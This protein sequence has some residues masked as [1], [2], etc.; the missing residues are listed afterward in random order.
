M[1]R[2]LTNTMTVLSSLLLCTA[3]IYDIEDD[4]TNSPATSTT[5]STYLQIDFNTQVS[6]ATKADAD[7]QT[8]EKTED[9]QT[10]ENEIASAAVFLYTSETGVNDENAGTIHVIPILFDEG[11]ITNTTIGDNVKYATCMAKDVSDKGISLETEYHVIAVANYETDDDTDYEGLTTL[12]AVRDNI[13]KTAWSTSYEDFLM[14][15]AKD[16]TVTFHSYNDTKANPATVTVDVQRMAARVDCATSSFDQEEGST[17]T[18]GDA[19]GNVKLTG[20]VLVNDLNSGSYLLKRVYDS[21]NGTTYLEDET[22]DEDGKATNYVIDPWTEKKTGGTVT[23]LTYGIPYSGY[24]DSGIKDEDGNTQE[25]PSYWEK[26]VKEGDEITDDE[27]KKWYRIGYTM[28]NTTYSEYTSKAYATGVVFKGTFEP[29]TV[30]N[31]YSGNTS[32]DNTFFKWNGKFYATLEDIM[33]AVTGNNFAKEFTADDD[34]D[35]VSDLVDKL[36]G[37]PTGYKAYLKEFLADKTDELTEV[38]GESYSQLSWKSYAKDK[39]DYTTSSGAPV[40]A[41]DTRAKIASAS[42]NAISTY[43]KGQCYYTWWIRHR[44]D[45]S[46]ETNGVMEYAIVRNNVYKLTVESVSTIGGDIPSEGIIVNV[47]VQNWQTGVEEEVN[48]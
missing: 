15:S 38:I 30:N 37:D 18:D 22:V 24:A 26:L 45:E 9:G 1:N 14:S 46:D 40:I 6:S 19:S 35:A 33:Y 11:E 13:C 7:E 16:A 17:V 8:S 5:P 10:Y 20:A 29:T 41:T 2:V 44:D 36:D 4:G 25:D 27:G 34:W 39:L 31:S 12:G 3:C 23:D 32:E 43:E 21:T 42:G 47:K 28:E 48:L